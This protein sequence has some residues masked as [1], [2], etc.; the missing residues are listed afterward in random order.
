MSAG[1]VGRETDEQSTIAWALCDAEAEAALP[2]GHPHTARP[3]CAR[4]GDVR[5]LSQLKQNRAHL[6]S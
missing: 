1:L 4:S 2:R 3:G 6:S 5:E